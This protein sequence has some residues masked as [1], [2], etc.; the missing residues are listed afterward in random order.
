MKAPMLSDNTTSNVAICDVIN[1]RSSW[2]LKVVSD[3]KLLVSEQKKPP[4]N[5]IGLHVAYISLCDHGNKGN[6]TATGSQVLILG[7]RVRAN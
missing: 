5:E 4:G 2:E 1:T 6:H 7:R 3:S